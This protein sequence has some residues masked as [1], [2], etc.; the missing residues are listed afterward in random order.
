MTNSNRVAL[1]TGAGRGIGKGCALELAKSGADLVINDRPES[2]DLE[3]TATEIRAL[4]RQCYPISA[5]IF[6]HAGCQ[7]LVAEATQEAGQIDILISNPA[8]SKR[9]Q[10]LDYP[11][12]EFERTIQGTLT[13]GFYL[14][15]LVAQHFVKHQ[16]AGRILFISSVQAELP[17]GLCCAYGAAK[18]GLNHMM[19]SISVELAEYGI[20]VNAI[21]P[22]WIDT[23]GEHATFSAEQIVEEGKKL[24]LG[25]LGLPD[26]I[27]KAAAFLCSA[28]ADYITGTVLPVDGGYRYKDCRVDQGRLRP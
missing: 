14:S 20:L 26:E 8:Y 4:G 12:E 19:R 27:G 24:P 15:Q 2:T 5:N 11:A 3:Q 21:E 18:A 6:D 9:G 23:P 1:V 22:G 28:N 25:R 13:S 16:I 7:Q 10:F 17:V